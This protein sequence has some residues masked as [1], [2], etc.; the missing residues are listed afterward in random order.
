MPIKRGMKTMFLFEEN[1][2]GST[3]SRIQSHVQS[4]AA[5]RPR[6]AERVFN[7]EEDSVLLLADRDPLSSL[8]T[9]GRVGR[10]ITWIFAIER[11]RPLA[12]PGLETLRRT[13]IILR[14]KGS[15]TPDE[16][17][18]F[19][20]CRYSPAQLDTLYRRYGLPIRSLDDL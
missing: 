13:A 15:L 1:L 4:D 3:V 20:A 14:S 16:T 11:P 19:S 5:I 8:T 17:L 7:P 10:I 18:R 2:F 12:N 6:S 9:L